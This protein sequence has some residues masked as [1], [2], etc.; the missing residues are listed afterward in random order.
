M[1]SNGAGTALNSLGRNSANDKFYI[2]GKVSSP[3]SFQFEK[4]N[5]LANFE[6]SL[7]DKYPGYFQD[8]ST[9]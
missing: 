7:M 1:T 3:K 6:R 4:Q 8:F 9:D 2:I 5:V